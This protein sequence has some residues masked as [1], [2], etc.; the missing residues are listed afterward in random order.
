MGFRFLDHTADVAMELTASSPD[1]LL[2]EAVRG[3]GTLVCGDTTPLPHQDRLDETVC[4]QDWEQRLVHLLNDLIFRLETR[5]EL[6]WDAELMAAEAG[7]SVSLKLLGTR[8]LPEDWV[9]QTAVKAATYHGLEVVVHQS[10]AR[11]I[12]IMDT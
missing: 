7:D 5:R 12:V 2:V 8:C 1:E 3:F 11:A 9:V 4:G 10:F 6:W